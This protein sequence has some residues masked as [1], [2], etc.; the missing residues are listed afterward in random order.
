MRSVSVID[1]ENILKDMNIIT[2]KVLTLYFADFDLGVPFC[3]PTGISILPD[4]Y[5]PR[6]NQPD[7]G[8]TKTKLTKPSHK[9]VASP[10]M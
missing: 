8:T 9:P 7:N 1:L 5:L 10:R 3:H 6:E 2:Q 4:F